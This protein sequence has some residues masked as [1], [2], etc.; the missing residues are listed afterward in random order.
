M[1]N[2]LSTLL[3]LFLLNSPILAQT[4][5][6]VKQHRIVFH[7]ASAD[8]VVHHTLTRQLNNLLDVWPTA[9]IEVVIHAWALGF[10]RQDQSVVKADIQALKEKGIV[11]AV[12]ENS[13]R[14]SK[15]TK[16]QMLKQSSFVPVGLAELV[17]KQEDGW[18]YIKAGY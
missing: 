10:M 4:N 3:C 6:A 11:F 18:S 16:E 1:K 8:T 2:T 15:L 13:M 5:S 12:C 9:Q 14:R 7:L 17:M